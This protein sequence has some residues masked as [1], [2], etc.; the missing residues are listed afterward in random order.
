MAR[1]NFSQLRERISDAYASYAPRAK[2]AVR[3]ASRSAGSSLEN[4]VNRAAR[5]GRNL[6]AQAAAGASILPALRK[7][8]KSENPGLYHT[9]NAAGKGIG[10]LAAWQVFELAPDTIDRILDV[11]QF[12][13]A[14]AAATTSLRQIP[15]RKARIILATAVPTAGGMASY[16]DATNL[17]GEIFSNASSGLGNALTNILYNGKVLAL[18]L[19]GKHSLNVAA[20]KP[21]IVNDRTVM[22]RPSEQYK[23]LDT[24]LNA[25]IIYGGSQ[26]L[27]DGTLQMIDFPKG[28]YAPVSHILAGIASYKYAVKSSRMPNS[29]KNAAKLAI[30]AV[31]AYFAAETAGESIYNNSPVLQSIGKWLMDTGKYWSALLGAG[32]TKVMSQYKIGYSSSP[33]NTNE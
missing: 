21:A 18:G 2:R 31:A 8:L 16:Y 1:I 26:V 4:I 6:A 15:N 24:G 23:A 33:R 7:E 10:T 27:A 13:A 14:A 30:P 19:I 11:P 32:L 17:V 20:E 9:L 29:M 25:A 5:G 22:V 12:Y 3:N 28:I